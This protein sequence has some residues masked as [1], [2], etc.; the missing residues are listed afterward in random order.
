MSTRS[1]NTNHALI[2]IVVITVVVAAVPWQVWLG[3]ALL[4]FVV[5]AFRMAARSTPP[6]SRPSS[7]STNQVPIPRST[8][9]GSRV[10]SLLIAQ[11]STRAPDAL[12]EF[13][14]TAQSPSGA[15]PSPTFRIP[16]RPQ[17]LEPMRWIPAGQAVRIAGALLPGG[18]IYVGTPDVGATNPEPSLIEPQLNVSKVGDF[19]ARQTDYWPSYRNLSASARRGYLDWLADGRRPRNV[20]SA[21]CS[22]FSMAWNDA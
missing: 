5:A 15:S 13:R 4:G 22:C 20:I 1:G 18:L 2:G 8:S 11:S 14:A 21:L 3:F 17:E 16:P 7:A 9:L 10:N 12:P 19:T 6:S